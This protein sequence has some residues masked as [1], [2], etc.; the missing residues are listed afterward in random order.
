LAPVVLHGKF[1]ARD[2]SQK[3]ME[4]GR[5]VGRNLKISK[6]RPLILV[7]TQVVE[8]SLDLDFDVLYSDP[9]PLEAL[10]QRFGR[11][12]RGMRFAELPVYVS[13]SVP[14]SC[15]VYSKQMIEATL[16]ALAYMD[17]QIL[18]DQILQENLDQIYSGPIAAWW[19]QEV[20]KAIVTFE[21]DVLS[22]WRAFASSPDIRELFDK[23]FDG[24]EVLPTEL[25]KEYEE[26]VEDHPFEAP[27]LMV[28]VSTAQRQMLW[29]QRKLREMN[30]R[31]RRVSVVDV[32]YDSIRG[33]QLHGQLAYS[34]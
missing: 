1:C 28:P 9:A 8:V 15:P 13:T 4:I 3:E 6:R 12:N 21:R 14:D 2:R 10:I 23:M 16:E 32:P 34:V 19:K 27:S 17:A 25:F 33:L 11:V 22:S 7:A 31:G 18:D 29:H 20:S 26:L 24:E 5:F 30:C